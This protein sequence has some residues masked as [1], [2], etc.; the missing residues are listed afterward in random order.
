MY[1]ITFLPDAEKSFKKLDKSV[2]VRIA[3]KID[4]L[5]KNAAKII[6]HALTSLPD[7]LKGLCRMRVGNYRIIY[8]IYNEERHVKIYEIEHRGKDYRSLKK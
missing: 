5:S 3:E 4:Y 1:K 8:W 6:H 2:Q 7:E